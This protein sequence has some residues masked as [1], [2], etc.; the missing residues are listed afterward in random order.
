MISCHVL[1]HF[2]LM[3]TIVGSFNFLINCPALILLTELMFKRYQ[4][5]LTLSYL[6]KQISIPYNFF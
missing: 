5:V 6:E 2:Q 1:D 3:V 4:I